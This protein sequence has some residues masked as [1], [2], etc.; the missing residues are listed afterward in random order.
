MQI[1]ETALFQL[2]IAAMNYSIDAVSKETAVLNIKVFS[3]E[4]SAVTSWLI[5]LS[6]LAAF[7]EK[8]TALSEGKIS[9][10][11]FVPDGDSGDY[12]CFKEAAD[13]RIHTE[14]SVSAIGNSGFRQRLEFQNDI[15]S[16]AFHKYSMCLYKSYSR[17]MEEEYAAAAKA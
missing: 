16:D 2:E 17:F 1:L 13:F 10:A 6:D 12:I 15:D 4:F 5:D 11:R 7:T 3:D 8:L 14:G 9:E